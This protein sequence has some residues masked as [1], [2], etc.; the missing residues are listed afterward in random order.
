MRDA[1]DWLGSYRRYWEEAL[2]R[3]A[4]LV[5]EPPKSGG[6]QSVQP[7]KPNQGRSK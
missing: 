5:E 4:E 1:H 3:L 7:K 6:E 2:D